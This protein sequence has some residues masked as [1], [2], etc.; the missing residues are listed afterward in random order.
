MNEKTRKYRDVEK[1]VL[2]NLDAEWKRTHD[3]T[4]RLKIL[5]LRIK[6]R[7]LWVESGHDPPKLGFSVL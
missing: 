5:C 2:G 6:C 7:D 3:E 4:L 1:L